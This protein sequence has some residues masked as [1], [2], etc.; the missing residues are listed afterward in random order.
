MSEHSNAPSCDIK[1][2]IRTSDETLIQLSSSFSCRQPFID[3]TSK[4]LVPRPR[5][6]MH[7]LY[8]VRSLSWRRHETPHAGDKQIR[9]L[10]NRA[11]Q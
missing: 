1:C 10:S 7:S 2:N 5:S 4:L 8:L 3:F 9:I 6:L 11:K